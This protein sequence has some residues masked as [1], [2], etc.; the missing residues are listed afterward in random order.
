MFKFRPIPSRLNLLRDFVH[1]DAVA[2]GLWENESAYQCAERI[3]DE[4]DELLDSTSHPDHYAEELA[5]VII[6]SLSVAGHLGIDIDAEVQR[7][8]E[9]N[10]DRPWKHDKYRRVDK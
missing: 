4:V 5:D 2:H 3:A 7:K 10:R 9:I 1:G 6:M 8:V